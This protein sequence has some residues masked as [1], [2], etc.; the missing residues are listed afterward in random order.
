MQYKCNNW[1]TNAGGAN[2]SGANGGGRAKGHN[3]A[4]SL[5]L[6]G[7]AHALPQGSDSKTYKSKTLH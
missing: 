4:A 1:L 3:M 6:K 5:D 2:H 7:G